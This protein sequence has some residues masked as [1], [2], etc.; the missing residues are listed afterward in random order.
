LDINRK[1]ETRKKFSYFVREI[2]GNEPMQKLIYKKEK[3][4]EIL[5]EICTKYNNLNDYMDAIWMWRGSSNSPVSNLK[6]ENDY[7]IMNYKKIKVKE[8][9]I[10]ISNAAMFDCIL[11]KVEGEEN[12]VPEIKN[13]SWLDKSDLYN[14]KAPSK[15]NLDN[16]EF[17]HQDYNKNED[18][19]Y[20]Y[21]KNPD[22]F[23]LSAKFGKSNMRRFTDKKLEI[24]LNKLLFERLSYEEFL[25]WFMLDINSYDKKISDFNN[26]LE[27]YPMLG[28]NHDLGEEIYKN[29]EKF[30]KALI[31][32]GI[33]YRARKLNSDEL[34]DEEKM[35]NPPVDEVPIFEGRYNHFAQ[36]FLYLSSLEKTAFVETIPSWH[37]ACCMA[38]F[39]LK[40][41]K[42]LL[43][44]RSKEIFEYEKAILYQII[45]ESDMINKETNARYKRPE[46]AV[47]RFL[48]DRA[49]ELDYN[50]IIY[51]SVKDRQG[52]NVVI[53]NPESLKNKNICMVKSPYKY[54]K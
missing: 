36:S 17:I 14:N 31:D 24:K 22:I 45:V 13:Y 51:N 35:W 37:S 32:N 9:Y 19:Q 23:L 52:E 53:F 15:V 20:I 40:K 25:D 34:Y 3:I 5:K 6:L 43:D 26:Y 54:K 18:N 10:N 28:L 50:G 48:A 16:D 4:K 47:T 41:I 33:F 8:L 30:D 11:I 44:L 46:Y 12:S 7:L 29:L 1:I 49:R 2:F 27:D 21:Y 39:K 38:K 42:K